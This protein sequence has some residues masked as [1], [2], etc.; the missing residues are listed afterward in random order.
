MEFTRWI[1]RN[2]PELTQCRRTLDSTTDLLDSTQKGL[3]D[4]LQK[5]IRSSFPSTSS[6]SGVLS[7][8]AEVQHAPLADPPTRVGASLVAAIRF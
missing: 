3:I 8:K 5:R 4:A 2:L 6:L 7:L 1:A